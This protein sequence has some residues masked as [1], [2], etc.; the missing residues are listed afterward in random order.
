MVFPLTIKVIKPV[1]QKTFEGKCLSF[2]ENCEKFEGNA[3]GQVMVQNRC[4]TY[5]REIVREVLA[6]LYE[7]S[8]VVK[9]YNGFMDHGNIVFT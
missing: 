6:Q 4:F 9:S 5:D 8:C 3:P 2:Q 7:K 1:S